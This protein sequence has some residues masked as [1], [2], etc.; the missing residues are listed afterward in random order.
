VRKRWS[1]LN[2]SPLAKGA[3]TLW[4]VLKYSER[5]LL[6]SLE[7]GVTDSGR[8][9]HWVH[10][11]RLFDQGR[12]LDDA[13]V[14]L[15]GDVVECVLFRADVPGDAVITSY[16]G[17]LTRGFVDLQ[18]NGGGGALFNASPTLEAINTIARAH[19]AF[20]TVAILP[21]VIT[22]APEIL[23]QAVDAAIEAQGSAGILGLH[24]EGPHISVDRR[25]THKAEYVR[26][27]NDTTFAYLE[28]LRAAQV[29]TLITLAP[30]VVSTDDIAR[31]ADLG[32]IVSVGHSRASSRQ[33]EAALD[34]GARCFTHLFNAMSHMTGREPGVVGAAINSTAYAGIICDGI[35]V[36]DEMV[37][38]ALRARPVPDRM[39]L[40]SDAMPTVG[41]PD[42]FNLYG[43]E[44]RLVDN[45]LVNAE[46]SLA[47]AHTTQLAGVQRLVHR[48]G[49]ALDEALRMAVSVPGELLGQPL[50]A[51]GGA[52]SE[53]ILCLSPELTLDGTLA[54]L[55]ARQAA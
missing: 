24:I 35:H 27:L 34:A 48:L 55:V 21:T 22:D 23:S 14:G 4:P 5:L 36:A 54:D 8:I 41:G 19:R 42:A 16:D 1:G 15:N 9:R 11:T 28:R 13:V 46:G 33:V 38:L 32:A 39:F 10:P 2:V 29:P 47:G 40:V 12:L 45:K 25:G 50:D 53:D 3:P 18:V 49:L 7:D 20:G 30:D 37:A 51:I 6:I 17:T 44:I 31:I 43:S 26:P 52:N